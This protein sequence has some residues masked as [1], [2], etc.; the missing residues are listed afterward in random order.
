MEFDKFL[1]N[2]YILAALTLF[3]VLYSGLFRPELPKWVTE[4]FKNDIF[5]V[6]FIALIAMI[7]AK[8]SPHVAII[9]AIVFVMTLHHIQEYETKEN[10]TTVENFKS[11]SKNSKN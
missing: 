1:N 2:E 6:V 9:I 7:P 8:Q 10:L 3:I 11:T 4:L 5:K